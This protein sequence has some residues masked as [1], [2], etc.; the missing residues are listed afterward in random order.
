MKGDREAAEMFQLA[1]DEEV[2][3]YFIYGELAELYRKLG[4][5]EK[6]KNYTALFEEDG[7]GAHIE[8]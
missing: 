1:A 8:F 6:Y 5:A 4:E 3:S 7:K 2:S